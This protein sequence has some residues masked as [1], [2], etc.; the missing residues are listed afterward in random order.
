MNIENILNIF[1]I[2]QGLEAH[3]DLVRDELLSREVKLMRST[4][5]EDEAL[6]AHEFDELI[7]QVEALQMY[8]DQ[9]EW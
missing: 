2:N 9:N 8:L 4:L 3:I 6:R 5:W 7:E 1:P